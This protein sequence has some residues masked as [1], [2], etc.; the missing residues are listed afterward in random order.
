[1]LHGNYMEYSILAPSIVAYS[2][3]VLKSVYENFKTPLR[4]TQVKF[5]AY[6]LKN[7]AT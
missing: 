4:V 1:M 6:I 3:N 7:S 2:L 5:E